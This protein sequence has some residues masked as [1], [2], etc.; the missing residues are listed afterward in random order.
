L[1][2]S[3]GGSS[4][5]TRHPVRIT[6][7]PAELGVH[8]LVILAV[9]GNSLPPLAASLRPLLSRETVIISAQNGIPWWFDIGLETAAGVFPLTTVDRNGHIRDALAAHRILGCVVSF[10]AKVIA[11]GVIEHASDQCLITVGTPDQRLNREEIMQIASALSASGVST[12]VTD[13]VRCAM[14]AKLAL[15]LFFGSISVLTGANIGKIQDEASLD[16]LRAEVI[17]ECAE[18]ARAWGAELGPYAQKLQ[19][20]RTPLTSHKSSILQDYEAGRE[21]ET[22]PIVFAPIELAKARGVLTPAL[23]FLSALLRLKL[24]EASLTRL[25]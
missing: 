13:D 22:D 23:H 8:D 10:P 11:P 16:S 4:I 2:H 18:I 25:V 3:E 15:N 20:W 6:D 1:D 9:K 24:D 17:A 14:W 7:K 19:T 12:E 5:E 21:L